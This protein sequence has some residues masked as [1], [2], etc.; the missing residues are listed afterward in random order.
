MK[1]TAALLIIFASPVAAQGPLDSAATAL[2]HGQGWRATQLLAP[3]LNAPATRTPD[4]VIL[5]ARAAASW[6]G[7]ATVRKLLEGQPWLDERFDRLGHR[8][9]AEANLSDNRN[10][11]ALT[12]ALAAVERTSAPRGASDQGKRLILLAR[13]YDRLD[14][15]D[16][17]AA[18]YLRASAQLPDLADWLTLR[19]AGVTGDSV[20][21]TALLGTVTL[22]AAIPRVL[23]TDALARDRNGDLSGAALRYEHLAAR[24]QALDARWRAA[25]SETDRRTVTADLAAVFRAPATTAEARD[26]IELATRITPPFT[27]DEQLELARRAAAVARPQ[28]AVNAFAA[29]A[30]QAPLA[31]RDRFS[32]GTEL[33]NLKRWDDA[34]VQFRAVR[35]PALAG[36]A[37][38]YA[39]RAILRTGNESN[40]VTAL[41]RVVRSFPKDTVAASLALYLL[42]DLAVDAGQPDSARARFRA[43]VRHYPS[44]SLRPH[45]E[46]VAALI[47]FANGDAATAEQELAAALAAHHASEVDASRYWLARSRL[48]LGDTAAA[49]VLLRELIARGPESYYAVRAAAR[50]DTL[51]WRDTTTSRAVAVESLPAVFAR[52]A[53]LDSLGLNVEAQFE[54]NHLAALAKDAEALRTAATQFAAVGLPSRAAQ[55]A[56]RALAAGA[57]RDGTLWRMIYPLPYEVVLREAA[58]QEHVDPLLAA[59]VIR[60]ESA[61]DPHATSRTDARGLLQVEPRTGAAGA[62]SLGFPEFDA[63]LL[64][65]ADVNLAIGMR[66]FA[67]ALARYPEAERAL[68]AYNAGSTPVDRWS[69]SLL[70]GDKGD[71]ELFIE[72]IPFVE[73]RSYVR[74]IERNLAVY[75]MLYGQR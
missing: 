25:T 59:A 45:A 44:S 11:Q 57:P 75:R 66:H 47:A 41:R 52:A 55:L 43:L 2:A 38:Y 12:Q 61:F 31:A 26:A 29:A 73:T 40:A 53:A 48:V 37:A 28:D 74:A 3:L 15:L 67:A 9:L 18:V 36:H 23:W 68:A 46:L 70:G 69:K 56:S 24:T 39:A 5:A 60:Q 63:A 20:R 27:R 62:K 72:R 19:A 8:L 65:V 22:A 4:V 34:A 10:P 21:R 35:D 30:K 7:W 1:R 58:A 51:P 16:S 13:A 33:G 32:Y 42:G 54:R 71:M 50:L 14:Q 17:A 6:E 49:R 64:W